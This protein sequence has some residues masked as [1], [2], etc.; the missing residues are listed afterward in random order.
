MGFL[1]ILYGPS[2]IKCLVLGATSYPIASKGFPFPIR[3]IYTTLQML[4]ISPM[5][6]KAEAIYLRPKGMTIMAGISDI[7]HIRT[8]IPTIKIVIPRQ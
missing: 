6:A 8:G 7:H 3:L 4:R 1:E 2:V 5:I